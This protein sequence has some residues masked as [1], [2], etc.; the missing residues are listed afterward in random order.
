M[1]NHARLG[2]FRWSPGYR[3]RAVGLSRLACQR[4]PTR[5]RD[6]HRATTT[7]CPRASDTSVRAADSPVRTSGPTVGA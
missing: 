6:H 2:D 3:L 4:P 5:S 1:E 7:V